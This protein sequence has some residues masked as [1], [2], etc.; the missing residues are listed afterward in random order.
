M[1]V[2]YDSILTAADSNVMTT[3]K[4]YQV[5]STLPDS[6]VAMTEVP[7][8][9]GEN[10]EVVVS[11]AL[12]FFVL[13]AIFCRTRFLLLSQMKDFL[14]AKRQY[15]M[16][17][18]R[19]GSVSEAI[20]VFLLI[21][22]G[23]LS[24]ALIFWMGVAERE[25]LHLGMEFPFWLV[26]VSAVVCVCFVYVK[27][28]VY[29]VVNWVFFDRESSKRWISGYLFLTSL[30]TYLL[31]PIL[32]IGMY[33]HLNQEIVLVSTILIVV[34]YELLLFYKLIVNFEAR[35]YGYLLKILYFCSVELLPV[36]VLGHL[37]VG[38]SSNVIVKNLIY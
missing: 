3:T 13:V 2:D 36:L 7:L 38:L 31:Y 27:A 12:I 25:N 8:S 37:A 5:G 22:M 20:H 18:S 17:K 24:I 33:A 34:L 4:Y 30:V 15:F 21:I 29:T 23:A 35:K 16:E 28:W 6:T 14:A 10:I 26:V 32:L 19:G 9:F 1:P 11:M